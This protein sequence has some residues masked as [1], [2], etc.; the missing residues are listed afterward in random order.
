MKA[1]EKLHLNKRKLKAF[2]Y[3]IKNNY[4]YFIGFD[5]FMGSF[6]L[7]YFHKNYE[8][9]T[10]YL[11]SALTPKNDPPLPWGWAKYEPDEIEVPNYKFNPEN[12]A[13]EI[14]ETDKKS[15]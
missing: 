2:E 15:L 8:I 13:W 12:N 3:L 14:D 11:G 6:T 5:R 9:D 10:V 4:N 1:I 7:Y